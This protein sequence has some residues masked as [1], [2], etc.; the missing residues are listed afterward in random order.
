MRDCSRGCGVCSAC[1]SEDTHLERYLPGY[2]ECKKCGLVYGQIEEDRN[3]IIHHYEDSDPKER[4]AASKEKFFNDAIAFLQ[5]KFDGRPSILDIG[6]GSGAFLTKVLDNRWQPHGV[7]I[8]PELAKEANQAIGKATVFTGDIHQAAYPDEFFDVV[9]IWDALVYADNPGEDLA[10][11]QRI[12][13]PH[14]VI[15]IRVRN[16]RF[17]KF[18]WAVYA[19]F[20]QMAARMGIKNPSVFHNF[21]YSRESMIAL[22]ERAG[23]GEIAVRNSPLSSGDP[24]GHLRISV[25]TAVAKVLVEIFSD[26][27]FKA[28][29]G[30]RVIGPSLLV[31]ARKEN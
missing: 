10:E 11:C 9:T 31:W 12:L 13:K 3:S 30:R 17:Q 18:A 14:G 4:V 24:Y 23:F 28:S 22:L 8:S 16:V 26:I 1:G 21:S 19:V 5:S 20:S 25:I 15:G 6:C 27:I 29:G 2:C 7:E